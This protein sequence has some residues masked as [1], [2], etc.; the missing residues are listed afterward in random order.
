[1]TCIG[2]WQ[3]TVRVERSSGTLV[4][5]AGMLKPLYDAFGMPNLH[6]SYAVIQQAVDGLAGT[7]YM[8]QVSLF[9]PPSPNPCPS[10]PGASAHRLLSLSASPL[11]SSFFVLQGVRQWQRPLIL[12]RTDDACTH[13]A[14]A[15]VDRRPV[16]ALQSLDQRGEAQ[17][18]CRLH[19]GCT[20]LCSTA[21][22][23]RCPLQIARRSI[24]LTLKP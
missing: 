24:V 10:L 20:P 19:L 14:G 1:M 17:R 2:K 23:H 3:G 16:F 6:L 15:S 18:S 12:V 4:L 22:S 7:R 9:A 13:P 5:E 8:L 11:L 21:F